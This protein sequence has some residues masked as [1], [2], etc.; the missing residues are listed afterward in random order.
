M[1]AEEGQALFC[2]A[3]KQYEN[4][5]LNNGELE[6]WVREAQGQL[7]WYRGT[8]LRAKTPE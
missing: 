8:A 6:R 7:I 2:L 4:L 1:R 5:A 3:S